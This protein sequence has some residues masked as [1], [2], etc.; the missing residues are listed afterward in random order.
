MFGVMAF[1]TLTHDETLPFWGW[2]N[3]YLSMGRSEL[4]LQFCFACVCGFCLPC[5]LPVS[6]PMYF[7]A[8]TFSIL[9]PSPTGCVGLGS[10][11]DAITT[12]PQDCRCSK[13]WKCVQNSKQFGKVS[14]H[15]PSTA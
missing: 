11:L 14:S 10:W 12:P 15:L 9:S 2:L 13:L 3:T 5:K 1:V 7:P 8:F 6:Q 4:I